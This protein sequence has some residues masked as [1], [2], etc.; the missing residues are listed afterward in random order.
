MLK[1]T[2]LSV[3]LL[4]AMPARAEPQRD[5]FEGMQNP[6]HL[7]R[8]ASLT[9]TQVAKIRELRK[10]QWDEEKEIQ[11]KMSAL[12]SQFD[13]KFTVDGP[14]DAAELSSIE[15]QFEQLQARSERAKFMV[16]LQI[17]ELLTAEQLT[18]VSQTHQKLKDLNAQMRALAPTVA[19]EN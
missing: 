8:G 13:E 7:L 15:Q 2:T 10:K 4:A 16:M 17:R 18:R 14:I 19:G 9:E 12:W 11:T 1:L 5:P 3:C 6:K